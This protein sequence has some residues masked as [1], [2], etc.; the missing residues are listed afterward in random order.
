MVFGALVHLFL[1]GRH[2]ASPMSL[3]LAQQRKHRRPTT[4]AA[5]IEPIGLQQPAELN[6]RPNSTNLSVDGGPVFITHI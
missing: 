4:T 6:K 2:V 5:A 3:P 1:P